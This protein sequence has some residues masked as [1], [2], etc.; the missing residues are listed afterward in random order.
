M[1]RMTRDEAQA[2]LRAHEPELKAAGIHG[3]KIFGSTARGDNRL[4][5]DID[6]AAKFDKARRLTLLD[7]VG[8]ERRLSEILG[9]QVDLSDE[10][11]LKARVRE[12]FERE[13]VLA[14]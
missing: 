5:S 6:L 7:M 10:E 13:A 12:N 4:D 9:A 8:F 11:R 2:I 14:F 1:L 3:L